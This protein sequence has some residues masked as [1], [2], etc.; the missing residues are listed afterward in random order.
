MSIT[1]MNMVW[2]L[3][4]ESMTTAQRFVLLA[5]A[6]VADDDGFCYPTTAYID[7]KTGITSRTVRHHL[8]A[9]E[10]DRWFHR[11]KSLRGAHRYYIDME[12]LQHNQRESWR[13]RK[14]A[15]EEAGGKK[16]PA[17]RRGKNLPARRQEVATTD[18]KK[19][20]HGVARSCHPYPS[21]T[22]QVEP[23]TTTPSAAAVKPNQ[24]DGECVRCGCVVDAG[25]GKLIGK[26]VAHL[27]PS[28]CNPA[29]VRRDEPTRWAGM[30]REDMLR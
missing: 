10:Q 22:H 29:T 21:K 14:N 2:G 25:Q 23:A 17:A 3:K 6:D 5:L 15:I 30:T 1:I 20:P 27:S 11:V 4:P 18:G 16:L 7:H 26:K 19:L 12:H 24:F 9:L 28:H 13:E 8:Q